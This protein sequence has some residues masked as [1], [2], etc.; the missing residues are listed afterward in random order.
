MTASLYSSFDLLQDQAQISPIFKVPRV[1]RK[2]SFSS[3]I[4]V[5]R[6]LDE[7]CRR[8]IIGLE[9]RGEDGKMKNWKDIGD[10]RVSVIS[11]L[12]PGPLR[13]RNLGTINMQE[14]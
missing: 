12:C 8:F 2:I 9:G 4:R 11:E 10:K 5:G 3:G 1:R 13:K 6:S 7:Q 14:L